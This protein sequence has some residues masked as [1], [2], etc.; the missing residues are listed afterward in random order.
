MSSKQAQ[1]GSRFEYSVRDLLTAKTGVKWERVPASGAGTLKGDLYCPTNH[2]Y[3]CIEC[4]SYKD[5][6]IKENLLSA[7]SNNLFSWWQQCTTQA[8][9]MNRKP[10]LVFKK[11]RGKPLIAVQEDIEGLNKFNISCFDMDATIYLFEDWLEARS[12]EELVLI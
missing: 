2:F 10:A 7:K 12:I 6:S 1:K 9:A 4:K 11:D 8:K 3:Y 5:S